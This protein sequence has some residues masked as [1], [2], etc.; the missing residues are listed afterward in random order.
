MSSGSK[1][2]RVVLVDDHPVVKA[3]LTGLLEHLQDIEVVGEASDGVAAVEKAEQLQPDVIAMDVMMPRQDGVEACR[4][5]MEKLPDSQVLMLTAST[6]RDAVVE[7]VA[8]GASGYL[9]KYSGGQE[10][11]EAIR[12]VARGRLRIPDQALRRS[13]A[14]VRGELWEKTRRGTS[15]LTARERELLTLFANGEPYARIAKAKGISPV[16]VRNTVSR[17]QDKLGLDTKQELVIWAMRN[18]LVQDPKPS[19]WP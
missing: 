1:P 14:M 3:G 8:A 5:I 10:M 7:A 4:T 9:Q 2:I 16:T 6:E 18:G 19:D 15:T 17:V 12:A 11:E 13:L